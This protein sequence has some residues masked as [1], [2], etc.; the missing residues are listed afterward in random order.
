MPCCN[1]CKSSPVSWTGPVALAS[2]SKCLMPLLKLKTP[3]GR[4]MPRH[5]ANCQALLQEHQWEGDKPMPWG[6]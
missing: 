5:K 1:A 3:S 6:Q 2:T 4:V